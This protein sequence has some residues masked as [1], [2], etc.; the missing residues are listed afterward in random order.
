VRAAEYVLQI[1][2]ARQK[3]ALRTHYSFAAANGTLCSVA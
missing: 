2:D 3:N 1:L